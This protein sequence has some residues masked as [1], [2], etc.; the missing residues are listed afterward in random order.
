M[1]IAIILAGGSGTRLWPLS[2]STMP[3]KFTDL[4]GDKTLF[5]NTILRL[6]GEI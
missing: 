3:K 2:R 1:N 6:K 5:T 4:L